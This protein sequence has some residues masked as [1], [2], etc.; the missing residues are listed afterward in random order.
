[1]TALSPHSFLVSVVASGV[2]TVRVQV[3]AG[4]VTDLA[5]NSLAGPLPFSSVA[6]GES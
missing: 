3:V 2:G 1:V 6:F 4:G 5:A